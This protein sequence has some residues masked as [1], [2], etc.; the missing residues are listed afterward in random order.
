MSCSAGAATP[1]LALA[2]A[3]MFALGVQFTRF[4]VAHTDSPTATMIQIGSAAAC[5]WLVSPWLLESWY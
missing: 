3:F 5:Y 4:G 2:A 1:A